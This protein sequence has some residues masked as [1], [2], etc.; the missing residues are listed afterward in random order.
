M[1]TLSASGIQRQSPV[2]T[3]ANVP[4]LLPTATPTPMKAPPDQLFCPSSWFIGLPPHDRSD[5]GEAAAIS[6]G[7]PE[8]TSLGSAG[9]QLFGRG[10]RSSMVRFM[11]SS[12]RTQPCRTSALRLGIR[13]YTYPNGQWAETRRL[14]GVIVSRRVGARRPRSPAQPGS[15]L[16]AWPSKKRH[17]P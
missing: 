3:A 16:R 9:S 11:A 8:S 14:T 5:V 13:S 15:G 6:A 7:R 4:R 10:F 1:Q 2:N 17:G 12:W